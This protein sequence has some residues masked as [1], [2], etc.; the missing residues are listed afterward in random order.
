MLD[1]YKIATRHG[2][3]IEDFD[4][5]CDTITALTACG[6]DIRSTK[7]ICPI[8]LKAEHDRWQR[9]AELVRKRERLEA[10]LKKAKENEA[11]FLNRKSCYFGIVIT[12]KDIEVSVLDSIDAYK[13][14]GDDMHHCVFS[15]AY[16]NIPD[17]I[18]LSAH[19]RNGN[20]IET[21]E[22]SLSQNKV[23]QSRGV[24]NEN[25][26]YHNRIVNL[27]NANAHRFIKAREIAAHKASENASRQPE[28]KAS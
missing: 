17:T 27:V 16:Y 21:V 23:I 2:Y 7:Y 5:W 6:K 25:T 13:R 19:D 9:K 20:R 15:N 3:R 18:I 24:N 11:N 4:L 14:E 22:F 10:Q 12:D 28:S 1:S 8:D 26:K